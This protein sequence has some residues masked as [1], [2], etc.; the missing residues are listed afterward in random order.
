MSQPVVLDEAAP[1]VE[2]VLDKAISP[3]DPIVEPVLNEEIPVIEPVLNEATSIVEPVD[4]AVEPAVWSPLE[5]AGLA[6]EP[7]LEVAVSPEEP[8]L[9]AASPAVEPFTGA[10][11]PGV[12]P[13]FE[14]AAPVVEPG[15]GEED[16]LGSGELSASGRLV[17]TLPASPSMIS[18]HAPAVEAVEA[19][20]TLPGSRPAPA[21]SGEARNSSSHGS[22]SKTQPSK[23]GLLE[24]RF[25]LFDR[26]STIDGRHATVPGPTAAEYSQDQIPSAPFG[27][28]SGA[29]P[30]G[31]SLGGSGPG[32]GGLYLL[33]ILSLFLIP[34]W[35]GGGSL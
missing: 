9:G 21:T 8:V 24:S 4:I 34:S 17:D 5:A 22:D 15:F 13:V 33:D 7:G 27:F 16:L 23:V 20:S 10:A 11:V 30:V 19:W 6:V 26:P 32:A 31:S 1:I 29:P 35:I 18:S 2:P 14:I 12:E 28:P 3:V 25:G